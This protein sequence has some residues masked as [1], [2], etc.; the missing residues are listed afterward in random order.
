MSQDEHNTSE[1]RAIEGGLETLG[2]AMRDE[3]AVGFEARLANAAA[4]AARG[5]GSLR[6]VVHEGDGAETG[7]GADTAHR[8]VPGRRRMARGAG[9]LAA[10]AA[11]AL[12]AVLAL[13]GGGMGGG[14]GGGGELD[15][16]TPLADRGSREGGMVVALVSEKDFEEFASALDLW[17]DDALAGVFDELRSET[18]LLEDSMRTVWSASWSTNT[19]DGGLLGEDAL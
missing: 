3:P 12:A 19:V 18:A 16:T 14:M 8:S 7:L 17:H 4:R 6:L 9:V 2:R 15:A 13:R 1:L 5:E 10:C 11:I